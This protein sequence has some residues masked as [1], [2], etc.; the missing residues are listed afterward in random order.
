MPGEVPVSESR[1]HRTLRLKSRVGGVLARVRRDMYV[2]S[3]PNVI[4]FTAGDVT[5]KPSLEQPTQAVGKEPFAWL[6]NWY[7][8]SNVADLTTAE[9]SAHTLLNIKLVVWRD[10][11]GSWAAA[12]DRCPHRSG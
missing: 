8:V 7:P 6:K 2:V 4:M 9:P 5:K 11:S 12:E 10:S 1:L 3:T